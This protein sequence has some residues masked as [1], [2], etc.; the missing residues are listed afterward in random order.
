MRLTDAQL[1]HILRASAPRTARGT[2][3]DQAGQVTKEAAG[4]T[5]SEPDRKITD[6]IWATEEV[7]RAADH[8]IRATQEVAPAAEID[9][10]SPAVDDAQGGRV[11]QRKF[12]LPVPISRPQRAHRHPLVPLTVA[13][14]ALLLSAVVVASVLVTREQSRSSKVEAREPSTSVALSQPGVMKAA[15]APDGPSARA[16]PPAQTFT[17][18]TA[19]RSEAP[20]ADDAPVTGPSRD[21]GP[22]AGVGLR[23][24]A[25]APLSA[26]F[27]R[28]TGTSQTAR[29]GEPAP[30][31]LGVAGNT[32]GLQPQSQRLLTGSARIATLGPKVGGPPVPLPQPSSLRQDAPALG[33]APSTGRMPAR[34]T[35][36]GLTA[37]L[38]ARPAALRLTPDEIARLFK[39]GE[40]Y[41]GQGRISA[42]RLLFQRAA[43]AC[44]MKATFALGATYDPIILKKLGVTLLDPNIA[45]ARAWY[46]QAR[47][48]GLSEASRQLELLSGLPR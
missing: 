29:A 38:A 18:S 41:M 37:C 20:P 45:T 39:R 43:Q 19:P 36:E 21:A 27:A 26:A 11:E 28:S 33:A 5:T 46:E 10:T 47:Q 14:F 42:A 31:N 24:V 22:P 4:K 15:D 3:S 9:E 6:V 34:A 25:G 7:I 8:V 30:G 32:V 35:S 2:P 17:P 1:Q 16:D 13:S 12:S 48:L 40:E 23:A 44:D